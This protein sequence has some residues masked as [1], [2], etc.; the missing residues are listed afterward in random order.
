MYLSL[1]LKQTDL[2]HQVIL[3]FH[4]SLLDNVLSGDKKISGVNG[5]Q[6]FF[7]YFFSTL[8]GQ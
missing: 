8:P 6:F 5:E 7:G 4:D 3:Y 2:G 1:L